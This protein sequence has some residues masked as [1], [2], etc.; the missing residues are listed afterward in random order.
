MAQQVKEAAAETGDLHQSLWTHIAGETRRR[1]AVLKCTCVY[2]HAH[3]QNNKNVTKTSDQS[4]RTSAG[5]QSS[6]ET[7]E[8]SH[9]GEMGCA[10][11]LMVAGS[12][13]EG[14]RPENG[15]VAMLSAPSPHSHSP[16][17]GKC[18]L[19]E[20]ILKKT[21]QGLDRWQL[22]LYGLSFRDLRFD[23]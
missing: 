4:N 17:T 8:T 18:C 16:P 7:P 22:V 2:A 11:C 20:W 9:S 10:K 23:S 19:M 1:Q 5:S 12:I 6:G 21:V 13:V 14:Q 15:P 3:T